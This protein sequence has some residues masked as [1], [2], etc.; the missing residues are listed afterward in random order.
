[1]CEVR[2]LVLPEAQGGCSHPLASKG[3]CSWARACPVTPTLLCFSPESLNQVPSAPKGFPFPRRIL[4]ATSRGLA[5]SSHPF[6]FLF[7]LNVVALFESPI[8]PRNTDHL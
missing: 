7:G 5:S 2:L 4:G 8:H 3:L 6:F 1:M